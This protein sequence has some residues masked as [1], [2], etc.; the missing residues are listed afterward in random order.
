MF[1][2]CNEKEAGK[3]QFKKVHKILISSHLEDVE[4]TKHVSHL[5]QLTPSVSL[6]KAYMNGDIGK[7][8]YL[9][10]YISTIVEDDELHASLMMLL[11]AHEQ[12]TKSG[13]G[14]IALV[15]SSDEI[16]FYY[17]QELIAYIELTYGIPTVSY[18][19]WKDNDF[20]I[21]KTRLTREFDKSIKKYKHLLF[22]N[23]DEYDKAK[24]SLK[25]DY[26]KKKKKNS[27]K[28]KRTK[29]SSDRKKD[30]ADFIKESKKESD[31][32]FVRAMCKV[33]VLKIKRKKKW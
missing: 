6:F 19:D 12:T 2:F 15:A 25:G 30:I 27:D 28:N 32:D 24:K 5:T 33:H 3:K 22:G 18:R 1:V 31:F 14:I 4:E 17:M 8:K 13:D 23:Y 26:S 29:G 21:K 9:K 7:K 10:K 20:K 11:L 16:N